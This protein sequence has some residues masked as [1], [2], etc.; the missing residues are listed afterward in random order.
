MQFTYRAKQDLKT[1]ASGVVE[2]V[3]LA[4]AVAHLKRMG[5]FPVEVVPLESPKGATAPSL[6]SR[7]LSRMELSLWA[8]TVGQGLH[9]GLSLTQA[10]HLLAEQE[11]VRPLGPVAKALEEKVTAGMS[12]ADA[13]DQP[14]KLFPPVAMAL[15]K[16]GEASGALEQ[17]L[18]GLAEQVEREAELIAK[19]RG[20]LIYPLF[21]L[22]I[23]IGTVAVLLW[24]VVPKLGLLFTEMGQP[25][26][27]A[28]RWLIRAGRGFIW[29]L[30]LILIGLGVVGWVLRRMGIKA[31]I[32]SWA[33][34]V[35]SRL[36]GFGRLI[37]HAEIARLS[38]TLSLLLGHGLPLPEAL[39]L[40]ADTVDG[41]KLKRQ[42][43]Q[44]R[45]AVVEGVG[46]SASLRRVGLTEPFLLTMVAMGEAQGDLA[47]AFSQAG[48]RYR[49]EVDR[50]IQVLSTLIEPAM[51]LLVGLIVGGIVFSMLL[52]IFQLNFTV[53]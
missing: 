45:V 49:Q 6:K 27:L 38:S 22:T 14:A 9:A 43:Q 25:L 51:I 8:R 33:I 7:P 52:P 29:G 12:L 24:V 18:Q 50:G 19:V 30:G 17:V 35:L 28:T 47:A 39:R 11:K 41:L 3:D 42:V 5:L 21:V 1:E 23:G 4:S 40:A 48:G 37:A 31:P 34:A 36:P 13:M 32:L 16:A 2:A 26:P 20:A 44:T 15:V 46:F 10:L 53:G